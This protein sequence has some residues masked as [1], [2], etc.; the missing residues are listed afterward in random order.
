[1]ITSQFGHQSQG[2]ATPTGP[3]AKASWIALLALSLTALALHLRPAPGRRRQWLS[4]DATMT[5]PT[6]LHDSHRPLRKARRLRRIV[7]RIAEEL[8]ALL[9]VAAAHL[10]VQINADAPPTPRL[11]RLAEPT[12]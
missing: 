11:Q 4:S 8:V 7:L 6:A 1:M 5:R 2:A 10:V 9:H 3:R 12:A